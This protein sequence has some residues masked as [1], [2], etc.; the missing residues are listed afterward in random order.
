MFAQRLKELRREKRVTQ[1]E[2]AEIIGIEQSSVAKYEGKSGV[3]PSDDVKY[4]LSEYFG[5][6]VEYLMCRTDVREPITESSLD[7]SESALVSFY[8][9]LN[10]EGQQKLLAYA[11]DLIDTGKYIKANQSRLVQNT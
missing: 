5:V 4:R 8:R 7:E 10:Q 2:L 1:R 9:D 3:I 11:S 6:S